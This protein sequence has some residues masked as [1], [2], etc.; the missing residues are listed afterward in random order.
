MATSGA[1]RPRRP[2]PSTFDPGPGDEPLVTRPDSGNQWGDTHSHTNRCV[3]SLPCLSSKRSGGEE[4][5]EAGE[6]KQGGVM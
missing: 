1:W 3:Y 2:W 6:E 4:E 5:E